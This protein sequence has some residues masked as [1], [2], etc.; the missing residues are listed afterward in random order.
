[1]STSVVTAPQAEP[2]T[3]EPVKAGPDRA[4]VGKALGITFG[5]PLIIGLMLWAFLAPTFHSG[6]TG[7]PIAIVGPDQAVT[8]LTQQAE[9]QEKHPDFV[10]ADS[11]GDAQRMIHDR[12]VVGAV[13]MAPQGS[14]IYTATGNG[15][16]YVQI[17]NGMAQQMRAAGQQVEVTDLAPTTQADPQTSGLTLLGLPL[18][19]GGIISAAGA[20]FLLRG[21]KWL[22]LPALP[23]IAALG[24][25][26]AVW[27]LHHVY[28]TLGGNAWEEWLGISM[29]I[30][31]TSM[32]TA[33]LAAL[34]GTAGVP[35][36]AVLTIFVSNPL[37]G[38]ATGP[39]FLPAGWS[40]LGQSM[41]IGATGY[42]IRSLSYFAG[43]GAT[44]AWWVLSLWIATGLVMLAF[45][46]SER[47]HPA[48]QQGRH[49]SH[50]QPEHL[51]GQHAAPHTGQQVQPV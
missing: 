9:Q 17:L 43:G 3:T 30:A 26:I 36:G 16:P 40:T 5:I 46:R 15:A 11:D 33:G 29:G 50:H 4:T 34:I 18:A 42:L 35:I 6:P 22:K 37:S 10:R 12:E 28:G 24:G 38:L 25:G 51:A 49:E 20:T 7:V 44:R 19:F 13:V 39:W 45:D 1:M 41:P 2:T 8:Q 32:L 48:G 14:T 23:A 31:A 27:M 21:H 47:H